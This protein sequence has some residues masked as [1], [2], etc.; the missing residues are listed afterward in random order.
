MLHVRS[1]NQEEELAGEM[2]T[3]GL[4]LDMSLYYALGWAL[5]LEGIFSALY[6]VSVVH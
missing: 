3:H 2:R 4:H 5:V 1:Q 6:H